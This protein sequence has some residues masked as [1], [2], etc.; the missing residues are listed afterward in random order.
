MEYLWNIM[1]YNGR[2][3]ISNVS[4]VPLCYYYLCNF[5][6]YYFYFSFNTVHLLHYYLAKTENYTSI[7]QLNLFQIMK[8]NKI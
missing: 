4:N 3:V 7:H 2:V 1:E 8:R 6:Y 5:N